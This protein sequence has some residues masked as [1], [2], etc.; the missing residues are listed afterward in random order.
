MAILPL[1]GLDQLKNPMTIS[2][3][4]PATSQLVA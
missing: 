2:G 4:E 1:E 3:I